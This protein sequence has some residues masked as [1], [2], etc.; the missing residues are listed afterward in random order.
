MLEE[1]AKEIRRDIISLAMEHKL[2][3]IAP[4]FSIVEI[5]VA[6]Y[7]A[8]LGQDD[9]FIL[10]KGHGCLALYSVLRA[11]G[12]KPTL[13]GHPDMDRAQGIECT[14]GSLGHGLPIAAG[15]ALARKRTGRK[16]RI[17]V[18]LG[19]GECQE[20]TTWESLLMAAHHRLDN[21]TVVVDRNR[22]QAIGRTEE[23][24][25]LGDLRPK[26]EALGCRVREVDGH[27]VAELISVLKQPSRGR[28]ET[29]IA[30]T[31]KGKGVS[32]MENRTEWHNRLP[33]A[34]ELAVAY[35]ELK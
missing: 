33:D 8:V 27:D 29:V 11:R 32:F 19:D 22:L 1:K 2:T 15:M 9:N 13:S 18:L 6:L 35:E 17:Y 3:H 26:F 25:S 23:V 10:S 30:H 4:A 31:I 14:T 21:L 7:E 24:A 12:L 34:E 20:G 5:L 28:P 16:G